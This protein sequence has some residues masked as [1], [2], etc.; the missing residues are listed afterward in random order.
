MNKEAGLKSIYELRNYKFVIESYQRGYRWDSKQVTEL[1]E[2]LLE[3]Q[4]TGNN[5]YCLQPIIVRKVDENKYELIDGQQRLT[6]I[7]ILLKFLKQE[8][9]LYGIEYKRPNSKEFLENIESEENINNLDF[10]F[11]KNAYTTI[12]KWFHVVSENEQT[13]NLKGRFISLL[14]E[15]DKN[16]RFIWYE[17][18]DKN[19][20]SEEIFTR[21]NVGKIPLND[22][23][24]IKAKLLYDVKSERKEEKYLKQIEI[25]N[26]WDRIEKDLQN[27]SFW[28]FLVNYKKEKSN[29]IEYIFD[30]VAKEAEE[31]Q[32][33]KNNKSKNITENEEY[34]TYE[35]IS[36]LMQEQIVN[37]DNWYTEEKDF[38]DN[39]VKKY[40][41]IFKDWYKDTE[42][43]N[44]IGFLNFYNNK[45]GNTYKLIKEYENCTE[46]TNFKAY[47]KN[48]IIKDV[49]ND[50]E[51]LDDLDYEENGE[52]LKKL[53]ILFNILTLNKMQEKFPFEKY[54]KEEWSLEHIHPRNI[55]SMGNDKEKWKS[56]CD[57][58][59]ITIKDF[60]ELF[61][62]RND[63]EK[64]ELYNNILRKMEELRRN[65]ENKKDA[66]IL[67]EFEAI[68]NLSKNE[69]G[70]EFMNSIANLTLLDKDTNS[71]IGNNFFDTKRR[72]LINAEKTGVYIPICTKN[73]FLKFYSKNPNHIYFWTKED[74]EDY[75]NALKEELQKFVESESESENNE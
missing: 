32:N 70:E 39:N 2:D 40:Y 31:K 24:L 59:I 50:V 5:L 61:K 60:I 49:I 28:R 7:Y 9:Y 74:R 55:K 10:Y 22:A 52:Q 18:K 17:V 8:E 73:V 1:L 25:G 11:M 23:E 56:L 45:E 34:S 41:Y 16:V 66:V 21:I 19:I 48:L 65:I 20:S 44:Y 12:K 69:Y 47:I 37:K 38:W 27:D 15:N 68:K 6:T 36:Q 67:E 63:K 33:S 51:N 29:R 46:K 71:K 4:K 57:D 3:F 13:G 14:L 53:L 43:Y 72:E 42:I 75:K 58:E 54:K 35:K 30:Y 62:N 26:E 64:F